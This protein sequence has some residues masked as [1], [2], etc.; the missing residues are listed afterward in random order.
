MKTHGHKSGLCFYWCFYFRVSV[1]RKTFLCLPGYLCGGGEIVINAKVERKKKSFSNPGKHSLVHSH[2]PPGPWSRPSPPPP[3]SH[4]CAAS[5]GSRHL[6]P[7]WVLLRRCQRLRQRSAVRRTVRWV[8]R[9]NWSGKRASVTVCR[10][11]PWR[12]G[13]ETQGPHSPESPVSSCTSPAGRGTW[14]A[15][16]VRVDPADTAWPLAR[17]LAP[18]WPRK[19]GI[20][21]IVCAHLC[22]RQG[23]SAPDAKRSRWASLPQLCPRRGGGP[24]KPLQAGPRV[25][26]V[27]TR[28]G[29]PAVL[30]P[31]PPHG[32]SLGLAG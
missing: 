28:A 2:S 12:R 30:A 13:E 1:W 18:A 21:C 4:L 9:V 32:P 15:G 5:L 23:P 22:A 31:R 8:F 25:S 3:R 17:W 29:A 7:A 14:S 11:H 24:P 26:R 19:Q 10:A 27:Q 6:L 16:Q 20:P